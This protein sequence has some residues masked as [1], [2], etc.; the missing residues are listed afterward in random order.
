[1]MQLNFIS[2]M[3]W[4][5]LPL[6]LVGKFAITAAFDTLYVFTAEIF[7]TKLR[8]SLLGSCSM[9]G[10]FGAMLAPQTPLLV[11]IL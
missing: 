1:M 2:D 9:A 6:Y 8:T 7:P 3:N 5:R 10:R 11:S 4:V